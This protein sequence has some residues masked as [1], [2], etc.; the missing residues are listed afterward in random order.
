MDSPLIEAWIQIVI[1]MH[2]FY[3]QSV[4]GGAGAIDGNR[5]ST[6]NIQTIQTSSMW[7]NSSAALVSFICLS[8]SQNYE[9]ILCPGLPLNTLLLDKRWTTCFHR[10]SI[11][12]IFFFQIPSIFNSQEHHEESRMSSNSDY[13]G[14]MFE[15]FI[16]NFP[17]PVQLISNNSFSLQF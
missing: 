12:P 7:V 16:Q 3:H 11:I 6:I 8:L 2:L 17:F 14:V 10:D 4:S 13:S 15:E 5:V 9:L 1:I